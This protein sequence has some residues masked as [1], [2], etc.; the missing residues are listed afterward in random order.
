[1]GKRIVVVG[2]GS[3][4]WGPKLLAD[5]MLK[6]TIADSTFILHD[7]S[8]SNAER[9]AAS[10][11]K[12]AEHLSVPTAV[13][14][15][16]NA[17][18]AL[19][20]AD[21]VIITISTGGLAA[22]A[23]DLQVPEEYGIFATVGDT[24]GPGGWARALR[25]IPVFVDLTQRIQR[26]APHAV[27][28]NYTN[29]LAQLTRTMSLCT[30]QPMVGMCH[31]LY[32]NLEFLRKTF[33]FA[34]EDQLHCTY[35][36]INHF[37]WMTALTINGRD[38]LVMLRDLLAEQ[39]LPQILTVREPER[40]YYYVA[41]EL[42]RF[43]GLLPYMGDRHICEFLP[44]YITSPQQMAAYHLHR[45]TIAERTENLHE[46]EERTERMTAGQIEQRYLKRSREVAADIIDAFVTGETF[47]DAGNVPNQG[48][49]PKLPL[50]AVV[51]TQVLSSPLGFVPLAAAPLPEP[52]RSWVERHIRIQEMTVEAGMA[53]DLELALKALAMDPTVGHLAL[54]QIREMGLRIL[55]ANNTYLPQFEGQ[56]NG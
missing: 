22:M 16:G 31:G 2:G 11:R 43:T 13:V 52:V 53:G 29:P 39:T 15:E 54:P 41:D 34:D 14:T 49:V 30:D 17:D 38:G 5:I 33:G 35:G 20:G 1:M 36:G 55:Q 48:Q 25:N 18:R 9:V 10:V 27:I 50:G 40:H 47:V 7:I 3:S 44:H 24:V 12:L 37:F 32:E 21:F 42:Y 28:L 4:Q 45:T 26:Q 19:A 56:L 23:H 6:E 8:Q 51:E 46:A